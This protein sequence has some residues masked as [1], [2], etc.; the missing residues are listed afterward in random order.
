VVLKPT[1]FKN[2]QIAFS[3]FA[4]GGSSLYSDADYQSAANAAAIVA[5]GGVG[6]YT[7]GD[8]QKFL[9]G[10]QAGAQ[11]N[12]EERTQGI[13]GHATPADLE[14]ALQL[15]YAYFTEPRK[16]TTVFHSILERSQAQLAN[17]SDDPRSVFSD[18]VKAI[19]GNYN[20]RRTGPSVAKLGQIDLD[21]AY[22]IYKERF[23]DASSFTFTFVG[24]FDIATIK[25][26]LEKYLG[27]LPSTHAGEQAKDL[28]IHIPAGRMEKII[29]KGTEPRATVYL[30]LSG[31]FDYNRSDLISLDA[32]K[33]TLEIRLLERLREDES[34]VYSPN[35]NFS[36]AK[37]PEGRYSLVISFGC[38]P[39]NADKLVASALDELAKLRN[40]GP[41]QANVD[42]WRAESKTAHETAIKTNGFWIN[43]LNNQLEN[44]EDLHEIDG[45]SK[46]LDQVTVTRL[47]DA[48]RKYL[49]GTNYIRLELL[50]VSSQ[51]AHPGSNR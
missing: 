19:L 16:D 3:G 50:P 48:A 41:L 34:G 46:D 8:L 35:A 45:Y 49:S 38:A 31:A 33:E 24:S 14:T 42:K 25:P 44:K 26:L 15:T 11:P 27:S 51:P 47:R 20:I 7:I 9:A 5:S 37:Y 30:V 36:A 39:Q 17:R 1:D 43:Y 6:N 32:L 10:K 23:A 13:S 4:P 28:G 12:I 18:S 29:Y 2:D 21:K 40:D 22:R